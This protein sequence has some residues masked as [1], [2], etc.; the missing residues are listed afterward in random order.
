MTAAETVPEQEPDA[1]IDAQLLSLITREGPVFRDLRFRVPQ[2]GLALV[3]GPSGSGRSA[4]L[5]TLAGRMRGWTGALRIGGRDAARESRAV[6]RISSVARIDTMIDLE[7]QHTVGEAITE[8]ALIDDVAP[9]SAA[10]IIHRSAREYGLQLDDGALI[11][12]LPALD[13]AVLTALLATVRAADLVIFDDADRGLDPA[14]QAEL[15]SVLAGLCS[16]DDQGSDFTTVVASTVHA[17][18]APAG[19]T[20][21]PL[22]RPDA[23]EEED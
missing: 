22:T 4:L 23:A 18:A 19:T 3:A 21:I 1:F 14:E 16:L 10:M 7:P 6:R 11:G 8:R 5:L 2:G 9:R 12:R 15:L 20:L 13:R 17:D